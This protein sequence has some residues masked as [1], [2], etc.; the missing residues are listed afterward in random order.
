[1]GSELADQSTK[2]WE[3]EFPDGLKMGEYEHYQIDGRK[4]KIKNK[5]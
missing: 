2:L 1:M 3:E 5:C 4:A